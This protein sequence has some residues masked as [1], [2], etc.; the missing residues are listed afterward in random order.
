MTENTL[1]IRTDLP[2][3]LHP[4]GCRGTGP[5]AVAARH[6][7]GACY[8]IQGKIIDLQKQRADPKLVLASAVPAVERATTRADAAIQ[9]L[10]QMVEHLGKEINSSLQA[11]SPRDPAE[12]RSYWLAKG[13]KAF[14]GVGALFQ[15]PHDNLP[16]IAAVLGGPAYLSGLKPDNLAALKQVAAEKLVPEKVAAKEEAVNALAILK[17]STERFAKDVGILLGSMQD[18]SQ[19][20]VSAAFKEQG[21]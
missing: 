7:L 1:T 13:S 9:T 5:A 19:D 4:E 11:G 10:T 21:S 8:E 3:S 2:P 18:N 14:S 15:V 16:T 12:I 6:A 17:K 20:L